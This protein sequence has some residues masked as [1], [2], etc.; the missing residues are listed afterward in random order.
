M[1][2]TL[3]SF[4][5]ESAQLHEVK[6]FFTGSM[7]IPPSVNQAYKIIRMYDKEHNIGMRVGPSEALEQFK[8]DAALLL[9]QA[10]VDWSLVNAIRASKRKVPLAV[11]LFVYFASEW[12]RDLDG[13]FKFAIDAAFEKLQL[14][15]NLVVRVDAEK[16]VDALQPR[17]DIE[18]RMVIR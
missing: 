11:R 18:L 12:K 1:T 3:A 17:V 8:K 10:E 4:S 7:P 13:I 15:D 14:N 16:L 2:G 9:S 6:P 5:S